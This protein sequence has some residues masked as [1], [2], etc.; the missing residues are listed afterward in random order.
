MSYSGVKYSFHILGLDKVVID[1]V[2][3]NLDDAGLSVFIDSRSID[4]GEKLIEGMIR[5]VKDSEMCIFL[6]ESWI[7]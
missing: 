6:F 1:N 7:Q 3:S 2:V 4:Y 5:G